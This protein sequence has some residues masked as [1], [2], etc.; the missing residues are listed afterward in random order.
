MRKLLFALVSVMGVA[1]ATPSVAT[2]RIDPGR[3]T[4]SATS[5]SGSIS[6]ETG[7]VG[8]QASVAAPSELGNRPADGQLFLS[9]FIY[10]LDSTTQVDRPALHVT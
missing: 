5:T 2:E 3:P 8:A 9:V 10:M 7:L 1:L 6:T 4:P